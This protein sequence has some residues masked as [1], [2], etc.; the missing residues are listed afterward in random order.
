MAVQATTTLLRKL[1]GAGLGTLI[2]T[3]PVN[4]YRNA[5]TCIGL[6]SRIEGEL[7][8]ALQK[9][10]QERQPKEDDGPS[11]VLG[12]RGEPVFVCGKR[13]PALTTARYD[14][15]QSLLS[16][17]D[18]GLTKDELVIQSKHSDARQILKRLATSDPDWDRIISFPGITGG[19]YRI[20]RQ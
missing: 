16:A 6:L 14:V 13:K 15:V 20:S 5:R 1:A 12:R 3:I 19:R 11:V 8:S 4:R 7:T 17:G 2:G 9:V 18:D 10:Q